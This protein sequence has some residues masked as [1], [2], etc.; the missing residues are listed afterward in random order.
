[1]YK[2]GLAEGW[3]LVYNERIN[4]FVIFGKIIVV[5]KIT[6]SEVCVICNMR[7]EKIRKILAEEVHGEE[8]S[9]SS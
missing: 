1:M 8:T 6:H 4:N 5:I 2:T 9:I 3:K 7:G